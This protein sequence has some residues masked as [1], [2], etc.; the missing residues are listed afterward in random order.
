MKITDKSIQYQIC[1]EEKLD[2]RWLRWFEDLEVNTNSDDQTIIS[3]VFDQSAL[4]GLLN[5][6]R[7]LGVT[8]ISVQRQ[9]N[10]S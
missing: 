2:D 4:H 3:G 7:D 8:I 5:R 9:S 1:L 10:R 6:I